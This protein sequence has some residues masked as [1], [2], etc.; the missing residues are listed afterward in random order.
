MLAKIS[1]SFSEDLDESFF[2][3]DSIVSDALQTFTPN[4][5]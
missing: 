4:F 2:L 5:S 3:E 1:L